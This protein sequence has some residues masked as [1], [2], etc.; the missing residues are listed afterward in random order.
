MTSGGVG[1]Y[2][3]ILVTP[4]GQINTFGWQ[5]YTGYMNY[6]GYAGAWASHGSCFLGPIQ[7]GYSD[8]VVL[9][10]FQRYA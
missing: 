8:N 1:N 5:N 7:P 9:W 3:M 4:D 6:L 10:L 2:E